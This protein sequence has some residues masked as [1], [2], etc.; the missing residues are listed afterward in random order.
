[1]GITVTG[2]PVDHLLAGE[3]QT[4]P[5]EVCF[6]KLNLE[7]LCRNHQNNIVLKIGQVAI[8]ISYNFITYAQLNAIEKYRL[9][10]FFG[11]KKWLG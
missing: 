1:M 2:E 9:R 5:I 8:L 6:N 4:I 11:K 10:D 3:S 7:K